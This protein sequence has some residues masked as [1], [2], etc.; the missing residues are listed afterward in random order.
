MKSFLLNAD[1]KQQ[2]IDQT[3]YYIE[4]A[5]QLLNLN[6]S[7]IPI[8]FD[9]K[10]RASGMFVIRQGSICIRYNEMIF[11]LYYDDALLNTVAHEVAHY[12]VYSM[13]GFKRPKPHGI[14]WKRVMGLFNVRPEVTSSYDVSEL[15]LHRQRQYEYICGCNTHQL[16]TTRHNR[17]KRSKAVYT[18]RKCR[19]PLKYKS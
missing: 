9:L 1:Q 15:P 16:S 12:V 6:L 3:E 19:Q 8:K 18:C 10:G 11:S 2:V 4:Q 14:E 17:V 5:N 13:Q 7:S